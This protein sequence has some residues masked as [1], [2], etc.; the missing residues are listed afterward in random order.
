MVERF[1][2]GV[3]ILQ[4]VCPGLVTQIEKGELDTPGTRV[5][6]DAAL[7]PMRERG[8][9]RV[10]MGCTHYPFV[11]PLIQEILGPDVEVINPAPAVARQAGR[12]LD[13]HGLRTPK[14]KLG[15]VRYLT[16]GSAAQLET[17]L[18]QLICEGGTVYSLRWVNGVLETNL[19]RIQFRADRLG[20]ESER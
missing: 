20:S 18:S 4:A 12:L 13:I 10:V 6:L 16:T 14:T 7:T 19:R 5:I 9:D 3:T 1:A 8:V 15:K 11:I 2:Q 17:M